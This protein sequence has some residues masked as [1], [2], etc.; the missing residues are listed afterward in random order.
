MKCI[1]FDGIVQ[2]NYDAGVDPAVG[3]AICKTLKGG[4]KMDAIILFCQHKGPT[5][6]T[7]PHSL[8]RS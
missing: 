4:D 6:V 1:I 2:V 5:L 3:D 8:I 7:S